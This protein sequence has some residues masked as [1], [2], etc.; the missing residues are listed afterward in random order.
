M[1]F[2]PI[3][4]EHADNFD[5]HTGLTWVR[6]HVNGAL[7]WKINYEVDLSVLKCPVTTLTSFDE[8]LQVRVGMRIFTTL[9]CGLVTLDF[10]QI[11]LHVALIQLLTTSEPAKS[12]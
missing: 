3:S 6:S 2:V 10:I 9:D 4:C 8:S 7:D 5:F 1:I 12:S 11:L